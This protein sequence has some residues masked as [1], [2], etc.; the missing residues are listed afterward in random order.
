MTGRE[1]NELKK[2]D[3]IEFLLSNSSIILRKYYLSMTKKTYS[4]KESYLRYVIDF[5]DYLKTFNFDV[6]D[7]KAFSTILPSDINGYITY[8]TE[9]N[10]KESIIA[11]RLY[12]IKNFFNYLKKDRI[13]QY[14]PCTDIEIPSINKEPN[15]VCLNKKEIEKVL[16]N[17]ENGVGSSRAINF[18]KKWSS[19]DKAIFLLGVT[20]GLRVTAI[21]EINIEDINFNEK[22]I[23]VVEKGN[24]T[25]ECHLSEKTIMAIHQW[26]I[27]RNEI[28][29]DY[30][31]P[32]L[33][34]S[35]R[36]TR[37]TTRS[38]EELI[39]KYTYNINKKITP[40]KLRSTCATTIYQKTGDIYLTANLIGHKNIQN[41]RKYAKV[42][43][44]QKRKAAVIMD[45]II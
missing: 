8:L 16:N 18:Q 42:S 36:K 5:F 19:R 45:E 20:T 3:K 11:S 10:N 34:I 37:I 27:D 29:G 33:F 12:A 26:I 4:T 24:V 28:M 40:H 22:T 23:Q 35:N 44:D 25:R 21:S 43:A 39:N 7:I 41:T 32:A 13:I 17:I 14:N 9:K 30:Y 15:V 31:S 1:E 6:N 2:K 38:I